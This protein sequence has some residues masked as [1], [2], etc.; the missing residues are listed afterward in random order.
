MKEYLSVFHLCEEM[1]TRPASCVC[2][3]GSHK[4]PILLECSLN[5]FWKGEIALGLEN[6]VADPV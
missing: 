1:S 2:N 5:N 3:Q 4:G 6:C